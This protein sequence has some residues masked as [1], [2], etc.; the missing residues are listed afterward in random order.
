MVDAYEERVIHDIHL[1]EKQ[2][3]QFDL[4]CVYVSQRVFQRVC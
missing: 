1:L 3:V 2:H 4:R